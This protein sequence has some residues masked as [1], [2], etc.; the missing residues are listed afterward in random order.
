MSC[1]P[2]TS[3]PLQQQQAEVMNGSAAPKEARR[4]GCQG[5]VEVERISGPDHSSFSLSVS[6]PNPHHQPSLTDLLDSSDVKSEPEVVDSLLL[7]TVS[8]CVAPRAWPS[9]V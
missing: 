6:P 2:L 4:S 3:S 7:G 8:T 1:V 5:I 9:S